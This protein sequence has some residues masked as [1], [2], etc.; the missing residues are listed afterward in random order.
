M[1]QKCINT[2]KHRVKDVIDG[3]EINVMTSP[4]ELKNSMIA[5]QGRKQH[6][7]RKYCRLK[8]SFKDHVKSLPEQLLSEDE[9][10]NLGIDEVN[11]IFVNPN[12][13]SL[14]TEHFKEET[15]AHQEIALF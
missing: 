1:H 3:R 7:D 8:R 13:C 2:A 12:V 14:M 11:D 10:E 4:T 9:C 15:V 5:Q 6:V